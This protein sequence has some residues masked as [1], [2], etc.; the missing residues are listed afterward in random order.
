MEKQGNDS[1]TSTTSKNTS[2]SRPPR[3]KRKTSSTPALAAPIKR[4]ISNVKST[5]SSA[6]SPTTSSSTTSPP[7]SIIHEKDFK[8]FWNAHSRV[9]SEKLWLCTKTDCVDTESSSW[10]PSSNTPTRNSW[11]TE[12][13][14]TC[15]VNKNLPTTCLPSLPSLWREITENAPLE[16]NAGA[17]ECGMESIKI[18]VYPTKKQQRILAS[19]FGAARWTYNKCVEASKTREMTLTKKNLRAK[20]I[21]KEA[22]DDH[23]FIRE[24]PFDVRDEGMND[25]LKAR[26]AVFAKK[27]KKRFAFKF[28]SRKDKTQSIAVLKKHWNHTRGIYA[29]L[30]GRKTLKGHEKLPKVLKYDSRLIRTRLGH[31]Y[32]CLPCELEKRSENQAPKSDLHATISLDPG[33]RTFMT[34]YDADGEIHYQLCKNHDKMQ[35]RCAMKSTKHHERYRIRIAMRRNQLRLRNLVDELHKKCAIKLCSKYRRILLPSFETSQMVLKGRRKLSS[36]SARCMLSWSH[37]RFRQRL[38][39]KSREYPWC[40]VSIVDEAYTSKTCGKCGKLN[41]KLGGS[42]DFLCNSC[43]FHA[44]RDANGAR[45]ILLRYLT[46]KRIGKGQSVGATPLLKKRRV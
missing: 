5:T 33:V 37:Y 46:N 35:K 32:L 38:L 1:T 24:I 27:D 21:K 23:P 2:V 42:K 41:T 28:R 34:G 25:F 16:T 15:L 18:R 14:Q 30:F 31:Y 12:K 39:M 6:L 19:W 4:K 17:K 43:N 22:L 36:K 44:D 26:R 45:N 20:Y 7:D 11:F 8:P 9:W 3:Q 13:I 29:Q 40:Q 10:S